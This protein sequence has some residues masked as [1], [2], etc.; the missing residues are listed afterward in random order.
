MPEESYT[1]LYWGYYQYPDIVE[2]PIVTS[3][4]SLFWMD[5]LPTTYQT[6]VREQT[7]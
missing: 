3:E 5:L 6:Y 2:H 7:T 1:L 4:S